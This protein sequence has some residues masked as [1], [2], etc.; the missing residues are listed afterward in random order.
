M[1]HPKIVDIRR[2]MYSQF[3]T[4]CTKIQGATVKKSIA[5]ATCRSEP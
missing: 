4:E 1:R 3:Y 5:L 2:V